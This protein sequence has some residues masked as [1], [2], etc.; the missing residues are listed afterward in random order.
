MDIRN[1]IYGNTCLI[2]TDN[3]QSNLESFI[4]DINFV[5][6]KVTEKKS[7]ICC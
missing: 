3:I 7:F 4:N 6:K 5:E 1:D 2:Y